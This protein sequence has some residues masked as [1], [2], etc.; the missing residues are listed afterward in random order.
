MNLASAG[1]LVASALDLGS[2]READPL[3]T[4]ARW[5]AWCAL[6]A[7]LAGVVAGLG[8]GWV[9]WDAEYADTLSRFRRR[10]EWGVAEF[11]VS[12]LVMTI[13]ALWLS[14]R[15]LAGRKQRWG[16]TLLAWIAATNLLYHFPPL[17]SMIAAA[18]AGRFGHETVNSA[19]FRALMTRDEVPAL[20][21]HFGLASL[22]VSGIALLVFANR[23]AAG[24]AAT[25]IATWGARIALVATLLQIPVGIWLVVS[26]PLSAQRRLLGGDWL[27]TALL[28]ASLMLTLSLLQQLL[29]LAFGDPSRV[30]RV[31]AVATLLLIVCLMSGVVA[32]L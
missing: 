6:G 3:Q 7:A 26:V 4:A 8:L 24:E 30:L 23:Q 11:V 13:Y 21:L 18:R 20:S 31:R 15:P 22:A 12:L 2:R 5:L 29:S 14:R 10:L 1:P 28:V 16:R 19:L 32:R 27:A 25:R 9:H 17:F